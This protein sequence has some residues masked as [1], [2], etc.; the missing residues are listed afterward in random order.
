M[1]WYRGKSDGDSQGKDN[2]TKQLVKKAP[3]HAC[4]CTGRTNF[5]C[6]E[7]ITMHLPGK[8]WSLKQAERLLNSPAPRRRLSN[9]APKNCVCM[10]VFGCVFKFSILAIALL[11]SSQ[12]LEVSTKKVRFKKQPGESFCSLHH[13][14]KHLLH[15]FKLFPPARQGRLF[16]TLKQEIFWC[17]LWF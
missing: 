16:L 1:H 17:F 5:S 3:V 2:W 9:W 14:H 10:H 12:N 4:F 7:A 11:P 13:Y 6:C 8:S 15:V